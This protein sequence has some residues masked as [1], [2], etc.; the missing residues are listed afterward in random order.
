MHEVAYQTG[1]TSHGEMN[2]LSSNYP[3]GIP[4]FSCETFS[5][6]LTGG[7]NSFWPTVENT[8]GIGCPRNFYAS[9]VS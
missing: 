4:C 2:A 5:Q 3:Q 1:S 6:T 8:S 7:D 9:T